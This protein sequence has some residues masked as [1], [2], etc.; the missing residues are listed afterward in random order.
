MNNF[1]PINQIE[2]IGNS[3][4]YLSQNVSELTKTKLLKLIFLIEEK[5]IKQTGAP[6]FGIEFKIWQFGPVSKPLFEGL[7]DID[8]RFLKEFV[9]KNKFDEYEGCKDFID[10]EFSDNDISILE[11]AI[12]FARH[13]TAEDLVNYTHSVNSLWRKGA[14]KNG[15]YDQFKRKIL[16]YTD[17]NIDFTLLFDGADNEILLDRYLSSM[18]NLQFSNK[19]KKIAIV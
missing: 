13:K 1:L 16:T 19:Y 3:I 12:E 7:T 10:D 8:T 2:K 4:I 18:E 6:F 17:F 11:W 9:I 14:I 15:V 5:S